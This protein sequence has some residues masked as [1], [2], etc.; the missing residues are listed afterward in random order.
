MKKF[1]TLVVMA[2][3]A[4][5]CCNS[6]NAAVDIKWINT[7]PYEPY[8]GKIAL[9]KV[10]SEIFNQNGIKI[11]KNVYKFEHAY[12][13]GIPYEYIITNQTSKDL[14]LKGIDSKYHANKNITRKSHWCRMMG[15]ELKY[16]QVWVPFY[17][18]VYQV[19]H[20]IDYEKNPYW[21]DFPKNY[22]IK[23]GETLRIL[24]MGLKMDEIQK[25]IFIFD[26][27]GQELKIE[28]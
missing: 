3:L 25:L 15:R 8:N 24:A 14:L 21:R 6:A 10:Q 19:N 12:K 13:I 17:S 28:F 22:T 27:N 20:P 26:D 11:E 5:A 16:W 4:I 9:E 7:M 23:S 2:L 1:T 18:L